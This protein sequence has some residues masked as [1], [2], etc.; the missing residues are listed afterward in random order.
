MCSMTPTRGGQPLSAEFKASSACT[1]TILAGALLA[2]ST[3]TIPAQAQDFPPFP[4]PVVGPF[5]DTRNMRLLRQLLPAEIG[6]VTRRSGVLLNDIWGWTSPTG[7]EYALVGTGDGMSI[8]RVTDPKNPQFIG[9]MPTSEP[10]DPS[11][12]WGDV[13]VFNVHDDD[14]DGDDDDGD[15]DDDDREGGD[16]F[17]GYAYYT[18]EADGVGINILEL[19]QLDSMGPAPHSNFQIP[20]SAVFE[21][22]GYDSAH[23][24]YVNQHTGF[25]YVVGV[26]LQEGETACD[27]EPYHP[28][29][30]NTMIL[31]LKRD[32]LN[33]DIVRCLADFGEHDAYVVNYRGP[34]RDYRGREIAFIFD[35]RDKD[36]PSRRGMRQDDTPGEIVG[37]A[38]EIWDVTDKDDIRVISSFTV[39]GVCFSH[40][41]WTSSNR[42]EFLLINDEI[43]ELRD[44]EAADGFFRT[45]FCD[46][47]TPPGTISNPGAYVVNVRDLDRPFLQ[48]RFEVESPGDNDHNFIREGNELY[49]AVYQAGTHVLRMRKRHGELML[50]DI[51]HMDTEPRMV[52]PF[53]GQ[54]GIFPFPHSRT[55]AAS[56]INNGL[57]I[58]RVDRGRKNDDDDDSDDS[59]SA[60]SARAASAT[61]TLQSAQSAE[62]RASARAARIEYIKSRIVY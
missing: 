60:V 52:D 43:D 8:V 12:L 30:F 59:K 28:S 29:R 1:R 40:Q 22:G 46:T 11:N 14:G 20:P 62:Q 45:N 41:G 17:T 56:D 61:A 34:D 50:E 58:M 32:P 18:T 2:S 42:H 5:P 36:A 49:W 55:I 35:G 7:E 25:A 9:I 3:L 21:E 16:W 10:E 19:N 39:P 37:G 13:G 48:E 6:A 4:E 23:N 44:A 33:P 15:D 31:D 27:N 53:N 38:T 51:A 47:D 24:V 57:M 54:W 26:G